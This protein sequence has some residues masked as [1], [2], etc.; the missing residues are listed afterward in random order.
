MS[1][2]CFSG[3]GCLALLYALIG[4]AL[5]IFYTG[6]GVAIGPNVLWSTPFPAQN[7]PHRLCQESSLDADER[8]A[9]QTYDVASRV[10]FTL[11]ISRKQYTD[12][13]QYADRYTGQPMHPRCWLVQCLPTNQN[14]GISMGVGSGW[15]WCHIYMELVDLDYPG[16]CYLLCLVWSSHMILHQQAH[17]PPVALE[18]GG[19]YFQL[20]PWVYPSH[21]ALC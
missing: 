4:I 1:V 21:P 15:F 2:T 16:V 17:Y 9:W 19:W 5:G 11:Y 12:R 20:L 14:S 8:C 7:P 10:C 3:W 18:S 6:R 13:I